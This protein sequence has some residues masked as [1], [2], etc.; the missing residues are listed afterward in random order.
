MQS[1][2]EWLNYVFMEP[3]SI[4]TIIM[5]SLAAGI[6]L[7]LG[8]LHIG[9]VSLGITFVFFVGIMFAHFGVR[10]ED[11]V[12]SFAKSFGL[13]LFVYALGLEVGP[14]FFPS[15]RSQGIVYNFYSLILIII[16]L[17][18][19]VAFR[20]IFNISMPNI[21]GV[22][23]GAVTNTPV[24][25]AVQN[26]MTNYPIHG[27]NSTADVALACAVSYPLG[28]V[29]VI[30][31]IMIFNSIKPTKFKK[32]KGDI[33]K[34]FISEFEVIKYDLNDRMVKDIVANSHKHFII[35]RIWRDEKLIIPHS[36]TKIKTGDHLLILSRENDLPIIE[37]IFGK[38]EDNHDW[39]RPDI[40]WNSIDSTLESRR[41]IITNSKFNGI[42]LG[43]LRLRSEYGI[44]IT[45]VD[46]AGIE[47]LASS[48][49]Y[50]QLG[51][52]IT[53][54]GESGALCQVSKLLGDSIS[55]LNKPKLIG[56]FLGVCIG[57][58][59]GMIPIYIPG[60]NVPVRLGLAGGPIIMGILMG[61]FG[62]RLKI[63]TYITTS[64]TQVIKQL[65]IITYLA[66]LGLGSG[67]NFISTILEGN[68]LLWI[69][70]GFIITILP[71]MIVGLFCF[72]VVKMNF[73][74]TAGML[75]G[76]MANPMALDYTQN[77]T[78]SKDSSV[79]YA[80]VYPISMFLRI[81]T[82]QIALMLFI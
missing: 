4:E 66:A 9:K 14:S 17:I 68:G 48:D 75:C 77:L 37:N 72:K 25:A 20:Y 50:L 43:A 57:S 21:L 3:S 61:A 8:K 59:L 54:V 19:V 47:L 44:N 69:A 39:N 28:V 71:T 81:I 16:D 63:T 70:L 12:L 1:I 32:K 80:S 38:R 73:A 7:I 10:C 49:L 26:T 62:P 6:G 18:V 27:A 64:A 35:S 56:F 58:I 30:L 2:L 33:S 53:V 46:R 13:I 52:R 29:G 22:M 11:S 67:A 60:I 24:L 23:S 36:K 82:A 34:P 51:D 45:R 42:K 15:L 31:A 65:G 79:A 5:I 55:V 76:S 40:D 41:I 74:E 78:E